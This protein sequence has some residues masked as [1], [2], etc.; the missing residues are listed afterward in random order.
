MNK[1]KGYFFKAIGKICDYFL[2]F[3][4]AIV[5]VLVGVFSSIGHAI[6]LVLSMG[7]CF[8]ILFLFNPYFLYGILFNPPILILLILT[9]TV[10]F[11]GKISLS[12]LKYIHY[13]GTE[14][15]YDR[16][17]YYLLGKN[18]YKGDFSSYSRA[19]MDKLE[20]ERIRREEERRKREEEEWN[21]RFENF[22]GSFTFTNFDDFEEFFRNQASG[23]YGYGNFNAGYYGQN[24]GS[25]GSYSQNYGTGSFKSQYESSCDTL[26]VAYMADKYEIKLAYRKMAK[27]YH[28]DINKEAG[29]TEKFQKINAAYE[30]LNDSNIERYKKMSQNN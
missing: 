21:R 6:G 28:P 8:F 16:S 2:R 20:K 25:S 9:V 27:K 15:L 4:I 5:N 14:Y 18:Y 7:G 1:F 24:S 26:G 30:F 23:S 13:V 29:A 12:Y 3:V 11:L 17:D 22:T 10:P 19:Y